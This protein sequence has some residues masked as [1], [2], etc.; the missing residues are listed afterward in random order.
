M[1]GRVL[2]PHYIR[3]YLWVMWTSTRWHNRVRCA[4]DASSSQMSQLRLVGRPIDTAGHRPPTRCQQL[5]ADI[6]D[7]PHTEPTDSYTHLI[8]AIESTSSIIII[9]I[10]VDDSKVANFISVLSYI[11]S[12]KHEQVLCVLILILICNFTRLKIWNAISYVS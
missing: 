4:Y 3:L 10:D 12:N 1:C 5:T 2:T 7:R 8:E 6:G 11:R 9:I